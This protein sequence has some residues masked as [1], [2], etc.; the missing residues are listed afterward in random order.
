MR[1]DI[2]KLFDEGTYLF[3]NSYIWHPVYGHKW[4]LLE[5][6][7]DIITPSSAVSDASIHEACQ[8]R[9]QLLNYP[10]PHAKGHLEMIHK[11]RSVK[12]WVVLLER[13]IMVFQSNISQYP[14]F[15]LN[16]ED[17]EISLTESNGLAL[18][19]QTRTNDLTFQSLKMEEVIEW[20]H[21]LHCASYLLMVLSDDLMMPNYD[22]SELHICNIQNSNEYMGE[23]IHEAVLKKEGSIWKSVRSR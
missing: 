18:F 10:Y 20:Y 7:L 3:G 16:I 22:L 4:T 1:Q 12:K 9:L 21:A 2:K 15:E 5:K 11:G 13:K 19:L 17:V 14:E 6:A 23:K 8:K